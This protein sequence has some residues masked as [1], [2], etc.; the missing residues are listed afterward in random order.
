MADDENHGWSHAAAQSDYLIPGPGMSQHQ[1]W[2]LPASQAAAQARYPVTAP[3]VEPVAEDEAVGSVEAVE[4]VEEAEEPEA[5]EPSTHGS[6]TNGDHRS[7]TDVP[8]QERPN[9]ENAP[10]L[11]PYLTQE[12]APILAEAQKAA[13]QIVERAR[14]EARAE[15]AQLIRVREQLESSIAEVA[16]W[17]KNIGPLVLA[18]QG[19]V[20]DMQTRMTELPDLIR[21]GLDPLATAVA[22][23]DPSLTAMTEASDQLLSME[24]PAK[25]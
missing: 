5:R 19:R 11:P 15:R 7:R 10:Q 16:A 4:A 3:D 25:P 23:M 18:F 13:A 20:A 8:S 12:L 2:T 14:N 9:I 1:P 6:E 21:T 22:S 17:R 24:A